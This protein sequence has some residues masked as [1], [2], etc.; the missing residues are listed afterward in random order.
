MQPATSYSVPQE[1]EKLFK[2]GIL[3]NELLSH[4]PPEL[5][6]LVNNVHFE[7]SAKPS[8]PIN[9]RFAES[10]S[11]LKAFEATMLNL[12]MT[13]KYGIEPVNISINT[14]VEEQGP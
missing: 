6:G 10:I 7:G 5:K 9:W 4:L 14:W 12:L 13:R 11:A 8:I 2:N 3:N 1:A